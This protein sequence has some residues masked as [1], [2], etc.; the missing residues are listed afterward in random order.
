MA[1]SSSRAS[2]LA[3]APSLDGASAALHESVHKGNPGGVTRALRRGADVDSLN[4]GSGETALMLAGRLCDPKI[5]GLLL[6]AGAS[7]SATSVENYTALHTAGLGGNAAI[8][9]ALL[10][11]GASVSSRTKYGDTPF[12]SAALRGHRG[13]AELLLAAGAEIDAADQNGRTGLMWAATHGRTEM[14]AS[15][16]AAGAKHGLRDDKGAQA[17]HNAT[18]HD[19]LGCMAALLRGGA[20]PSAARSSGSGSGDTSLHMAVRR[21]RFN[22]ARLLLRAGAHAHVS[23]KHGFTPLLCAASDGYTRMMAEILGF[24]Q[25]RDDG[26]DVG[27]VGGGGAP[28]LSAGDTTTALA[29]SQRRLPQRQQQVGDWSVGPLMRRAL[30]ARNHDGWTALHMAAMVYDLGSVKLLLS[31]GALETEEDRAFHTAFL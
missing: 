16:L 7:V 22:A 24:V 31:Y 14:V 15:L 25:R 5:V 20:D 12:I 21:Q 10:R 1:A 19:Q 28:T 17:L 23:D 11:A 2:R 30:S 13:C 4:P 29:A 18:E 3:M 26:E 9:G 6:K 8:V 27:G